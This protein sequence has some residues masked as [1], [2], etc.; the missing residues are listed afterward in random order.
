MKEKIIKDV[1]GDAIM[2]DTISIMRKAKSM[3]NQV[4]PRYMFTDSEISRE[5]WTK[6]IV[7]YSGLMQALRG[8][9]IDRVYSRYILIQSLCN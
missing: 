5:N 8:L 7:V 9:R 4:G 2:Y 3:I 1:G 6:R